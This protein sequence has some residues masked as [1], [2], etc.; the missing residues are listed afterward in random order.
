MLANP[1]VLAA[2]AAVGTEI[3]AF[4]L[5]AVSAVAAVAYY[6][7]L[8]TSTVVAPVVAYSVVGPRI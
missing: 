4:R 1:K 6:A 5:T 8:A 2:S 7:V 3:A